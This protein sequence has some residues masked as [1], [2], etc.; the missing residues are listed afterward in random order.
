MLDFDALEFIK[1]AD[2]QDANIYAFR[3]KNHYGGTWI[4]ACGWYPDYV[5]RL[6]H[7]KFTQFNDNIVHE[8]LNTK[9]LSVKKLNVHLKHFPIERMD[10]MVEKMNR[11]TTLS[12]ENLHKKSSL[13][14]A[15]LRL[16]WVFFKDY[17]LRGGFKYG[18]KGF[19]IAYIN[20][21]GAFFKYAKKYEKQ[22]R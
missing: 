19:V 13:L 8:S 1:Q 5:L 17:F 14:A 4:K 21:N 15:I 18:Y 10:E 22:K 7:K 11:Y 20:A 16:F 12:S 6:F 9:G 2:L 3:R